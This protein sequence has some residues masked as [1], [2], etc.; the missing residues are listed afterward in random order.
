[1]ENAQLALESDAMKSRAA[2]IRTRSVGS[3][4]NMV[5]MR[6]FTLTVRLR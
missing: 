3:T 1:M 2:A 6:I 4:S 5:A